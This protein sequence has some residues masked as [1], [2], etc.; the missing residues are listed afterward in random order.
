MPLGCRLLLTCV[1]TYT[2]RPGPPRFPPDTGLTQED[3]EASRVPRSRHLS[4]SPAQH[5]SP[6]LWH[7]PA[8]PFKTPFPSVSQWLRCS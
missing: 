5:P 8:L 4:S 3:W 7:Q 1:L 2:L 6:F